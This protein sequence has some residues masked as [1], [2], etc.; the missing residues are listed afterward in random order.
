[1]IVVDLKVYD[2]AFMGVLIDTCNAM[3]Y[4]IIF[5]LSFSLFYNVRTGICLIFCF[6]DFKN[7]LF[8]VMR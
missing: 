5:I 3:I 7:M 2:S 1:M 8:T 4:L 6:F